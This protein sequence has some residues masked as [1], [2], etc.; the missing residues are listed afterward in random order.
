MKLTLGQV[1]EA[2]GLSRD[3][4]RH[5]QTVLPPL[6]VRKGR[7][8]CFSHGDLLATAIV[9]ALADD[10][11]VPVSKLESVASSL[12]EQCGQH[13]W[14]KFERQIAIVFPGTWNVSFV[15]DSQNPL[16]GRAAIA[17]PCAPIIALLRAALMVE[18]V[19]EPQ[20]P[21]KFPLA[22]VTTER[23]SGRS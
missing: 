21:F 6:A 9:K 7:K 14:T 16:T 22:A 1:Q 10:V 15:A 2:L 3:A 19:D 18:Q 17:I 4:Y 12:F 20:V 11:G 23:G 5:W 8:P 13:P